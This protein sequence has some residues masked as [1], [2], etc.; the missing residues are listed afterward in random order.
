[1]FDLGWAELFVIAVV[2]L[3]VIG[4]RDLPKTMRIVA[5]WFRKA[6]SLAR[7]FQSGME[8]LAREA[9]LDDVKSEFKK[10]V[11]FKPEA[12][13]EASLDPD[14]ELKSALPSIADLDE[15]LDE[16]EKGPDIGAAKATAGELGA[17]D[18]DAAGDDKA[19]ALG[20]AARDQDDAAG[21]DDQDQAPDGAA[22]TDRDEAAETE[23]APA[24]AMIGPAP[25]KAGEGRG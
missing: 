5:S 16:Q 17:S 10:M 24:G 15:M 4:P 12:E 22:D 23:R 8:D 20:A 1:M 9:E 14:G 13:L 19:A 11:D 3:I 7:E 21:R 2:A 25:A 6:R 18:G